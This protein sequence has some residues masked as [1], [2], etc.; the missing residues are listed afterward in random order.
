[1]AF[2]SRLLKQRSSWS[3]SALDNK[4]SG[5]RLISNPYIIHLFKNGN[6]LVKHSKIL[7]F[8]IRVSGILAKAEN[9]DAIDDRL[10]ICSTND[11]L[12]RSNF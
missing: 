7:I 10:S 6:R 4:R 9:S 3:R 1:M 5:G 11:L 2:F 12:K 8:S